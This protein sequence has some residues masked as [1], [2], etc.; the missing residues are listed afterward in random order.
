MW[1]VELAV[2]GAMIVINASWKHKSASLPRP[3]QVHI[4]GLRLIHDAESN[5]Y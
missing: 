5:Y 2:M 4:K 1:Y 3:L